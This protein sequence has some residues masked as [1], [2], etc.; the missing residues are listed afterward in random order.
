[1][2]LEARA[3]PTVVTTTP[4]EFLADD[5]DLP[6]I[7]TI[8]TGSWIDGTLSTWA[9]EAD[10][11]LAWQRLVEARRA[12]VAFEADNPDDPGLDLAWESLY[13]AEGSDWYWWYG[14]DQDSG[15]DEMWDVLFKVHLSNIY[16]AIN[17][18]LPPYLQD[19]WTNPALPDEAASAVIEPMIDGIALPGEWDGAA[20]YTADSV[21]GGGLDIDSFHL[22]YD[23]SNLYLR[24]DMPTLTRLKRSMKRV[25]LTWRCTSCSPTPRTST[26]WRRT[27][28][29][30]TATNP[31][32]PGQ[33]NGRLRLR[34]TPRRRAGQVEPLDARGKG[35]SAEQWALSGTSILGG[36]AADE[37]Y[38]FVIPWSDLGLAPRYT[39]R[40]KVVTS[41]TDSL[42]Y[43]DGVDMEVAPPAPAEIVLPDLEQWVTLL[44]FS[45]AVG[46][47]TGDGD[48][49]YLPPQISHRGAVCSMQRR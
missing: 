48:Y 20:V 7:E 38:E 10:E 8:G 17:L 31:W 6:R 21:D 28:G 32:L 1:M 44:E 19:L 41:W 16:R 5:P 39:T 36:C 27:S 34:P 33:E 13:I 46:D 3:H 9:G 2:V 12:L 29:P 45:D 49:T 11:S 35:E 37:V 18:D 4:G 40:V 43:G 25:T 15:Y 30:T 42:A 22:G 47:E 23:A 24:V 14:L 26:R